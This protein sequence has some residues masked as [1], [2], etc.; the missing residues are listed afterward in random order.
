MCMSKVYFA[1]DWT[2][3]EHHSLL[4]RDPTNEQ[5]RFVPL[6]LE[7]CELPA[8]IAQFLHIDWRVKEDAAY[9]KLLASCEALIP[10]AEPAAEHG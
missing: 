4:F 9:R 8:M 7:D 6:L 5:R 3:L 10:S 1:S 2:K